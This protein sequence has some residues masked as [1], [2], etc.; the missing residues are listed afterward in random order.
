MEAERP[1]QLSLSTDVLLLLLDFL[2]FFFGLLDQYVNL[3]IV[4]SVVHLGAFKDRQSSKMAQQLESVYLSVNAHVNS[5]L[6]IILK[7]GYTKL[8]LTTNTLQKFM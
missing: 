7:A 3:Y 8:L 6:D 4:P 1:T 5:S 2:T